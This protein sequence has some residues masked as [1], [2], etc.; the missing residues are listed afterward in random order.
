MPNKQIAWEPQSGLHD[1]FV[2][3]SNSFPMNPEKND[4]HSFIEM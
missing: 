2:L 3:C 1:L 4:T